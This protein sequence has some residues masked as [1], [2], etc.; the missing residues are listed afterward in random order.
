M[1]LLA[2]RFEL[3]I[4][5]FDRIGSS[6]HASA[7]ARDE[8]IEH[9]RQFG[10]IEVFPVPQADSRLR[11]LWD[12]LRSL[13]SAKVFTHYRHK[14]AEFR[15]R[16]N[17]LLE[18]DEFD[19][20]H[21]DTLDLLNVLPL[22]NGKIV[23]CTHHNVESELLNERARVESA[24]VIGRYIRYQA[25]LQRKAEQIWCPRVAMNITVSDR[26]AEVLQDIAPDGN[27]VTIP[28]GVDLERVT[29]AQ[30]VGASIDVLGLG[31]LTWFPNRDAARFLGEDIL[32]LVR[33]AMP[34]E[35]LATWVGQ[36]STS[37]R[38]VLENRHGIRAPGFVDS[39][40]P[41]VHRATC[42]VLPY[43]L[44][45][46]SR[47]KL[48]EALAAGAAI[49]TTTVGAMGVDIRH[50]YN[51]LIADTPEQF[52][53]E[54]VRVLTDQALSLRLAQNARKTAVSLYGWEAIGR[55]IGDCYTNLMNSVDTS[56][57]AT[58]TMA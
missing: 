33:L 41:Y 55:K 16:L 36:G 7:A 39:V 11:F 42:Y 37:D 12:H 4:I 9:L 22:L 8:A 48:L 31:G 26:D 40:L 54:V 23:T 18:F 25:Q 14:S 6:R 24:W 20:V 38:A 51:A 13:L 43:R 45:G 30:A 3:Q 58:G 35:I 29:P 50:E 53:H 47:L 15:T 21:V 52:A 49:V 1:R 46:G 44:G 27:F 19:L 56:A 17:E 32:P 2:D 34:R 5:C 28:N 10:T 57:A